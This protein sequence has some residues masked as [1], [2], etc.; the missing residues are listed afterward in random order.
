MIDISIDTIEFKESDF[1]T[2]DQIEKLARAE[3][4]NTINN[5]KRKLNKGQD[6]N[7]NRLPEYSSSYKKSIEIADTGG[8]LNDD[9]RAG[10]ISRGPNRGKVRPLRKKG[11]STVPNLRVTGK[12]HEAMRVFRSRGG[13]EGKIEGDR[14]KIAGYVMALGFDE[15]FQFGKDD[16]KRIDKSY[17]ALVVKSI[18]R[19]L[20]VEKN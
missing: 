14:A 20:K 11:G 3:M 4:L 9:S 7:K 1:L 16:R 6:A 19:A 17:E 12:L 13:A 5:I 10:K 18:E 8:V 2:D 15:W